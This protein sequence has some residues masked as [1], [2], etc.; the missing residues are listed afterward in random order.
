MPALRKN[1]KLVRK[2]N[3]AAKAEKKAVIWKEVL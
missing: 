3:L 1:F 2:L